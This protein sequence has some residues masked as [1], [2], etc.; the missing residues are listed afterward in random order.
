V[1]IRAILLGL[2]AAIGGGCASLPPVAASSAMEQAVSPY[3][4]WIPLAGVGTVWRPRV[5]AQFVPYGS[6]GRWVYSEE[7][8][9]F[10][11]E[12]PWGWAAFHYGNWLLDPIY[13]WVWLP[14]RVWAPAWV[15]WRVGGGFVGWAPLAPPGATAWGARAPWRFVETRHFVERE[16]DH[17]FVS[18]PSPYALT[19]PGR[20]GPAAAAIER[21]IR[22]PLPYAVHGPPH[23]MPAQRHRRG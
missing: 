18:A 5:G 17:H 8:W 14:G 19:Q 15:E 2:L 23:P 9:F 20:G 3:G 1:H 11:S 12:Y 16:V 4:D 10:E 22:H 7:G 6:S 21:E 13:G